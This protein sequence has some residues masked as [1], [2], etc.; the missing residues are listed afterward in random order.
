MER[1]S[2][3][4]G[5]AALSPENKKMR[6]AYIKYLADQEIGPWQYYRDDPDYQKYVPHPDKIKKLA[7][8]FNKWVWDSIPD[9]LAG[10]RAGDDPKK[11]AKET[12]IRQGLILMWIRKLILK[13]FSFIDHFIG[14]GDWRLANA[15][16]HFFQHNHLM[17]QGKADLMK[18]ESIQELKQIVEDTKE[19]VEEFRQ[20]RLKSPKVIAEG[21]TFLRGDW[22]YDFMKN[23]VDEKAYKKFVELPKSEMENLSADKAKAIRRQRQQEALETVGKDGWVIMEI[24][25]KAAACFHGVSDWCTTAPGGGYFKDIYQPSDPLF[26]FE[27]EKTDEKFQF[28]YGTPEF[29][30]A[31]N[32]EVGDE[33]LKKLHNMLMQTAASEKYKNVIDASG[34]QARVSEDPEELLALTKRLWAMAR[35]S[36][37]NRKTSNDI[38]DGFKDLSKNTA[39]PSEALGLMLS[40]VPPKELNI[41]DQLIHHDNMTSDVLEKYART[42]KITLGALERITHSQVA[43]PDLIRM[44]AGVEP[45]TPGLDQWKVGAPDDYKKKEG[46]WIDDALQL[47]LFEIARNHNTPFDMLLDVISWG[48]DKRML[49]RNYNTFAKNALENIV[50]GALEFGETEYTPGGPTPRIIVTGPRPDARISI[51]QLKTALRAAA[52]TNPAWIMAAAQPKRVGTGFRP[53]SKSVALATMA[54]DYLGIDQDTLND[55]AAGSIRDSGGH[56]RRTGEDR[57][58]QSLA[59]RKIRIKV[60]K[61]NETPI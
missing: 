60:K 14:G 48:K 43:S 45:E 38:Y 59:E 3:A 25:N 27:N 42:A 29:K 33:L 22:K 9:D 23:G 5:M 41:I 39:T 26:I 19:A 50:E 28:H 16:E 35:S 4:E 17:P 54:I 11:K 34:I 13:D 51:Y 10:I 49:T 58:R 24:H 53:P 6:Q 20:S 32:Y 7:S 21:T 18:I 55:W 61:K 36:G 56:L 46:G 37:L 31:A 8:E 2:K 12:D 40:V 47:G 44:I 1:F 15:F 52:E 57:K 30:N